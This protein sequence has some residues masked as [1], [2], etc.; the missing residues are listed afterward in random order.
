MAGIRTTKTNVV[1]TTIGNEGGYHGYVT[2]R[3]GE[4]SQISLYQ[5]ER[6][7]VLSDNVMNVRVLQDVLNTII[8][9][10]EEV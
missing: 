10:V 2:K 7:L 1:K 5:G 8:Q 6:L 3:N 9:V 4:V